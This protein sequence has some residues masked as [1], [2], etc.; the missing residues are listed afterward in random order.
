[1]RV[2]TLKK[3]AFALFFLATMT[4]AGQAGDQYFGGNPPSRMPWGDTYAGA[5]SARNLGHGVYIQAE[6]RAR[7][8]RIITVRVLEAE[9]SA[10]AW[11]AGVCVIRPGQ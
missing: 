11:E 9:R 1:M 7:P 2:L 10:C 4:G 5:S 8:V 6:G 3:G